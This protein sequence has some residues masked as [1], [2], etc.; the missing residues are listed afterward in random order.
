VNQEEDGSLSAV[1][2]L[3]LIEALE[4]LITT[5][6]PSKRQQVENGRKAEFEALVYRLKLA[7]GRASSM[8]QTLR[9]TSSP[10]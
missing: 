6:D 1:E 9:N 5:S 7:A 4:H 2:T 3:M 10:A 8:V